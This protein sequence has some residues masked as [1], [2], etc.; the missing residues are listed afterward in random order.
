LKRWKPGVNLLAL[1]A[2]LIMAVA[3]LFPWWSYQLAYSPRTDLYP[4]LLSGPASEFLGYKRSPQMALLSGVLVASILL[5][6]IGSLWRGWG[7]RIILGASSLLVALAIWRLLVRIENVTDRFHVPL[8]GKAV[9]SLDGFAAVE[10]TT[11]FRPGLYL[12]VIGCVLALLAGIFHTK[13][14]V[15]IE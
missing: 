1:L 6:F 8:Q 13:L 2:G 5:C 4:Y 10:V 14:W 7:G 9:G 15:R 3:M 11:W 12:I